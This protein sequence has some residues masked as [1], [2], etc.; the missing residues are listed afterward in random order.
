MFDEFE[1]WQEVLRRY[2]E[3]S[4]INST[5]NIM[6]EL[7]KVLSDS[8]SDISVFTSHMELC[9]YKNNRESRINISYVYDRPPESIYGAGVVNKPDTI[10]YF[11][12]NESV[13][14]ISDLLNKLDND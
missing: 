4:K 11:G 3:A 6:I 13:E 12:L 10:I 8:L 9:I 1:N 7:V 14:I 2:K 5:M